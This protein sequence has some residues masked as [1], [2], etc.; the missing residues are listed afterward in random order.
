MID[1]VRKFSLESDRRGRARELELALGERIG[2]SV[3]WRDARREIAETGVCVNCM[4]YY[5]FPSYYNYFLVSALPKRRS[6]VF[7]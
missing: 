6:L 5:E 2:D 7:L 1:T 3:A 4:L